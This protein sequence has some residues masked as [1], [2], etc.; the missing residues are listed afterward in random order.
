MHATHFFR[1]HEDT[2]M[3]TGR[4]S[5]QILAAVMM[6]T[7][8]ISSSAMAKNDKNVSTK[9]G[10]AAEI[11]DRIAADALLQSSIDTII[12]TPGPQGTAGTNG[13]DGVDGATGPAGPAGPV[14]SCDQ[15]P[16]SSC[17]VFVTSITQTGSFGGLAGADGIC[18]SLAEG[19]LATG[20]GEYKAWLSDGA[21]SPSNGLR[22]THS[23]VPYQLV[24]GTEVASSYADLTTYSAGGV[25]ANAAIAL[26]Q[27]GNPVWPL[28]PIDTPTNPAAK[29]WTGTNT[30]GESKYTGVGFDTNCKN[31]SSESDTIW[32]LTGQTYN[33]FSN[34]SGHQWVAVSHRKCDESHRLY[35][36]EQ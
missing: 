32:G 4:I 28:D 3:N 14:P 8:V 5:K 6:T 7:L 11:Q 34:G 21:N 2:V 29:V 20:S 13:L 22:F 24:D 33:H 12:L 23:T 15:G 30:A 31:W 10:L 9:D 17:T 1:K 25:F 27:N 19:S 35:C 26:D 36:F 18:Q 16:G